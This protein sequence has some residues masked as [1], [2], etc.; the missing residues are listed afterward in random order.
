MTVALGVGFGV[1]IAIG[2]SQAAG[3]REGDHLFGVGEILRGAEPED[4]VAARRL[5][6]H[7]RQNGR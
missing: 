5:Q 7:A 3:R 6:M 4:G 2:Q 1:V